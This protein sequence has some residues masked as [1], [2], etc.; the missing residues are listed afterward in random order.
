MYVAVQAV[1]SLYASGRITGLVMDSGDGVTN[2]VPIYEGLS[3]PHAII[4]QDLAGRDLTYYLTKLLTAR[5]YSFTVSSELEIVRDMK[6]KHCYVAL[7]FEKGMKSA[8]QS[9]SYKM[10]DGKVISLNNERLRCP[11][12]MFQPS[13]VEKERRSI[14]E[15]HIQ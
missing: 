14:H 9:S 3:L 5:G 2:T 1:M 12:A 11:E 15:N 10:P 4:R 13:F 7:D 8:T 6:E